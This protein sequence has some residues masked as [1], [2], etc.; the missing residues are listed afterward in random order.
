MWWMPSSCTCARLA[1]CRRELP[2]AHRS[3]AC[4]TLGGGLRR[5][6]RIVIDRVSHAFIWV[7]DLDEARDFYVDQ[8]GLEVRT[9]SRMDGGFRWLT[10]GPAG[11][12]DLEIGLIVPGFP[13]MD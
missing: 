13:M 6:G 3:M 7:L 10:V 1:P 12:P 5:K 11:Q 4:S 8:L 2:V 9:D